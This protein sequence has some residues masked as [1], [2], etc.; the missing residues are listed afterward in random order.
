MISL[1]HINLIRQWLFIAM[2]SFPVIPIKFINVFFIVFSIIT[3]FLFIKE[4]PK[5]II[6]DFKYYLIFIVPFIPYLIEFV[7][8]PTNSIIQFEVEKK[9][10]FFIAPISFAI[11]IPLSY[12]IGALFFSANF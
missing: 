9:L 11:A 12:V 8:F 3:L 10:L 1:S 6:S 7:L 5:W 2:F 4:K